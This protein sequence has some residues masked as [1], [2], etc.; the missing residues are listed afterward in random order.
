MRSNKQNMYLSILLC[1]GLLLAGCQSPAKK[2]Q[3]NNTTVV[4]PVDK[5]SSR[6]SSPSVDENKITQ[7]ST[8]QNELNSLKMLNQ[9]A[10]IAKQAEFSRLV[11]NASLYKSVRGDINPSTKATIDALF[12]FRTTRLCADISREVMLSLIQRGEAN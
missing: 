2:N 8:C 5:P 6:V 3:V 11:N 9:K 12:T 1:S 4:Q 7:I 10:Y